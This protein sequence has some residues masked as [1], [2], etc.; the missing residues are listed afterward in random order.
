MKAMP[1]DDEMKVINRRFPRFLGK[2]AI[3]HSLSKTYGRI[4]HAKAGIPTNGTFI[5]SEAMLPPLIQTLKGSSASGTPSLNS[6]LDYIRSGTT[7]RSGYKSDGDDPL[8]HIS[9]LNG[10]V[11]KPTSL[12]T[13]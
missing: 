4:L 13:F 6:S 11:E 5:N 10:Q 2:T 3:N 9:M 7:Y 12:L 8:P 1:D